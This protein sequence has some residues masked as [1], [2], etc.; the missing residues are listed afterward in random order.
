[1]HSPHLT[2]EIN[3]QIYGKCNNANGHGHNYTVEITLRGPVEPQTGM[4]MNIADLKDHMDHTIMKHLDHKNLDK[5]VPFFKNT[6]RWRTA[7]KIYPSFYLQL[8]P[9]LLPSQPSTSENVAIYIWDAL[10]TRMSKPELL[11]EVKLYETDKNSVVYRGRQTMGYRSKKC[12]Q[13]IMSSDS[14]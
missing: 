10:R 4:V 14:D 3:S 7:Y 13:N 8:N 6:V 5:D 12:T 9:I 2:D 1:M 11:Y